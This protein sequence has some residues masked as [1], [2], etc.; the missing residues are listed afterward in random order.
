MYLAPR[1]K[2]RD[3]SSLEPALARIPMKLLQ[4]GWR[5]ALTDGYSEELLEDSRRKVTLSVRHIEDALSRSAWLVGSTYSLAD[6]DAF[7]ICNSLTSLTPG[8]VNQSATPR[9]ID[10]LERIRARPA[11][12]AAL[13]MS[14]TGKPEHAF[15]P[16]P[17]HARW[18]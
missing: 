4:E 8:I 10:W 1:F 6:I 5:L 13:A 14:R 3:V 16:G 9:L 18:G 15:A 2:G 11:V 17:E 7:A 12:R